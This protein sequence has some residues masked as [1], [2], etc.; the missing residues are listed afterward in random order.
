MGFF[1][2][3]CAPHN[4]LSNRFENN[5]FQFYKSYDYKD[6]KKALTDEEIK[7]NKSW[8]YGKVK[9][10]TTNNENEWYYDPE[11]NDAWKKGIFG[12][13]GDKKELWKSVKAPGNTRLMQENH[14]KANSES[15]QRRIDSEGKR[16]YGY[17]EF[18]PHQNGL[19]I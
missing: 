6:S 16:W 12:P 1:A 9:N 8:I 11:N 3:T 4:D 14:F 10:Q 7:K 5:I 15:I 13:K 18:V 17:K 19:P 2:L